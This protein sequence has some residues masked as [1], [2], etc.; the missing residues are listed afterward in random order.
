MIKKRV[1][2][3]TEVFKVVREALA[4]QDLLEPCHEDTDCVDC[5]FAKYADDDEGTIDGCYLNELISDFEDMLNY[6]ITKE[7]Q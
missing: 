5:V 6:L 3:A 2:V 7:D 1:E 4:K